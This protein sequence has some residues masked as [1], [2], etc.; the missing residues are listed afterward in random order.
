MHKM[1]WVALLGLAACP[2]SDDPVAI[3]LPFNALVNGEAANCSGEYMVGSGDRLVSLGD[4]RI[5]ISGIQVQDAEGTWFDVELSVNDWQ[6]GDVALLDFEDGTNACADSGTAE[7]N[8][9]ITGTVPEGDYSALRFDVGVPFE[10]N[11][12]DSATAPA[13]LNAPGMFWTW[14]GGY[15]FVRVDWVVDGDVPSRWNV[16]VGSTGCVSDGSTVGPEEACSNPNLSTVTLVGV[17]PFSDTV[18][19]ELSEL[20]ASVDVAANTAETPPGCMSSPMEPD[21]CA[22]AYGSLGLSFDTGDC[23]DN[24]DGQ[25]LFEA[26]AEAE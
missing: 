14:Q 16:H 6:D 10:K 8:S 21:D 7:T 1:M 15:K 11:H 9:V 24:C 23:V 13:P 12:N 25:R 5:L 20:V 22:P 19:I 18:D 2:G 3:T 17:D 4:A 26:V